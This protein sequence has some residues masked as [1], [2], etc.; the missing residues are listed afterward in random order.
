M[1]LPDKRKFFK[2]Q[3]ITGGLHVHCLEFLWHEQDACFKRARSVLHAYECLFTGKL[4]VN[5]YG[6][7]FAIAVFICSVYPGLAI[8]NVIAKSVRMIQMR[9]AVYFR[10]TAIRHL[11]SPIPLEVVATSISLC[12]TRVVLWLSG[13]HFEISSFK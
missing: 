9:M 3:K 8:K 13:C 7:Y 10:I 6:A 12:K 4:F 2:V 1:V 11:G 5:F